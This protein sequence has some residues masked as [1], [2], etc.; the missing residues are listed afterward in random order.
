MYIDID[1]VILCGICDRCVTDVYTNRKIQVTIKHCMTV[2]Y[3]HIA[4]GVRRIANVDDVF[5]YLY[6]ERQREDRVIQL[7]ASINHNLENA[8][9]VPKLFVEVYVK[10]IQVNLKKSNV[11]WVGRKNDKYRVQGPFAQTY[12]NIR[13]LLLIV[14]LMICLGNSN[15]P[16]NFI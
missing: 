6:K 12:S 3:L 14:Y 2:S 13:K 16:L 10:A 15:I 5:I 4:N 8:F 11:W 9:L 1:F 7:Q